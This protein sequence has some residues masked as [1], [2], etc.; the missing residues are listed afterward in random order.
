VSLDDLVVDTNVLMHVDDPRQDHQEDA[1]ALLQKLSA[2]ATALCVDEG[3][4]M[5]PAVN[6]SLIGGEYLQLLTGAHTALAIIAHMFASDRIRTV[7][8]KVP[9]A[10]KKSIEQ[11]VRKKRDRTFIA[12]AHNSAEGILCSH[13]FEDMQKKKRNHIRRATG[14]QIVLAD[15]AVALL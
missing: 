6:T 9:Q 3:F 2:A 15:K 13:D 14:V 12:V 1:I 11:C 10:T 8:R 7:R 5:D 4:D